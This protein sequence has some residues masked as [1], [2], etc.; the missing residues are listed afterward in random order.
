MRIDIPMLL[1]F[2][3]HQL[4]TQL[5]TYHKYRIEFLWLW[6]NSYR[7]HFLQN[8]QIHP[9]Y[10]GLS[11]RRELP[12]G[13]GAGAVAPGGGKH[14]EILELLGWSTG[15]NMKENIGKHEEIMIKSRWFP[16]VAFFGIFPPKKLNGHDLY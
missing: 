13:S 9:S 5:H 3:A 15:E 8:I 6:I 1:L 11:C 4:I 2:L 14:H 10:A 16:D 7:Y 12:R